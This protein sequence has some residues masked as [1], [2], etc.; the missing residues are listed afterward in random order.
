MKCTVS[1][2]TGFIGRHIVELLKRNGHSVLVW[3]R[4]S[5]EARPEGIDAVINLAG[6][7]VAQR[8]NDAVRARIRDSRVLGTRR[9]VDAIKPGVIVSASAVGIYGDRGDEILTESS[10]TGTGFL[11]GVCREWEAEADRAA[12]FGARVVKLRIGM[13]LGKDGGA[14]AK[15]IPVFRVGI[16]GRL[17][18]GKQ[19]M[20][21]IHIDDVARLFVHAVE[22]PSVCGVWNATAPSPVTNAEFTRELARALHRP[23]LL[24][25]P[26]LALRLAFGDL[27]RNMLD[28]ARAV[29]EAALRA[30]FAFRYATLRQA[31]PPALPR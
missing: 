1:G 15:M 5:N 8:W 23:A 9:L 19:W 3:S 27:G 14:L 31:L 22:T 29:P 12:E 26:P 25:V 20:P 17:G 7:P 21:W 28:S 10:A 2:A 30:G 6:E 24:R 4:Q 18:S 16:G 13:V 11:A